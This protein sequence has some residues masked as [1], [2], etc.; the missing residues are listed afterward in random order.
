MAPEIFSVLVLLTLLQVKHMLAD[1]FLQT[2][3]MLTGR[4]EYM[5]MGRMQH[6]GL[7]GL[8][9]IVVFLVMGAPLVFLLVVCL[10]E[11]IVHYH[12]DWLKGWYSAVKGHTPM[13]GAYWRAFGTDQLMHQLTYVVMI[14]VWAVSL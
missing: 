13:D 12:I 6:A 3:R 2:R 11:T 5:H 14:W 8:F 1:F 9:S 10:V 4:D 7:H